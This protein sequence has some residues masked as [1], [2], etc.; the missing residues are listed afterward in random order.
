MILN[1]CPKEYILE[2]H[3]S[4]IPDDTLRFVEGMKEILGMKS[5][6][7]VT[8]V[9]RIGV[10]VFTCYR[11]R[12]D[13]SRTDHTGK[14]LSKTQ[15][16]VSITMEAIERYSAEFRSEDIKNLITGSYN[17]LRTKY[18]T[19]DPRELNLSQLSNYNID[20]D[21]YWVWGHDLVKQ[22]NILVP[23]CSVYHPFNLNENFL[24]D[25][26]TDGLA[27]GNTM[28]EA[29]FHG[30]TETIERD[31]WSIAKFRGEF[32]DA[33]L[34]E[35]KPENQFLIDLIE[36]FDRADIQVVA[37]D[38]SSDIGVPVIAAFSLDLIHE[39][40]MPIA[41]FGAHLDPKVALARA[42]LELTTTRALLIQKY[43]IEDAGTTVPPYL[44]D[45]NEYE[46]PRFYAYK[47]KSLAELEVGY[48]QDILED[49]KTVMTKLEAQG[50]QKIIAVDLT[51]PELGVPTVR[52]IV[53]GM[54]TYCF[55]SSRMG[56]RLFN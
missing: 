19:L 28:E 52:M 53:P 10:P 43:G 15:A 47:Q 55:D 2:T 36:K 13:G 14:G 23:A 5:F 39:N 3:R 48:S 7:E 38:I 51:R 8:N 11:E 29:V 25:T 12:L 22:E 56:E 54:E 35:G 50:L 18:K 6:R 27:S 33:I 44:Q 24:L 45:E 9:D 16:Q 34:I 46:D 42:L 37:K 1:Q 26:N 21:L 30:L 40:M 20:D 4:R 41:G 31:A 32:T 17:R 49:I